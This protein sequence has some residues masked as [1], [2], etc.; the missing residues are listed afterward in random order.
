MLLTEKDKMR[1]IIRSLAEKHGKDHGSLI[2]ILRAIQKKYCFVSSVAMQEI[3]DLLGIHP[4]EVYGVVTFYSFLSEEPQGK[5]IFRL[6][7]TISCDMVDKDQVANQLEID[8]GIKFGETSDDGMYT[9]L[10]TS[11]LGMCDQ[12]PALMVNEKIFTRVT[13]EKVSDIIEECQNSNP[14]CCCSCNQPTNKEVE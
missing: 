2:P 3:A 7:E 9:L 1:E 14:I 10:Y 12:G 13:A 8:L 11:C 4:T 6:C 5:Y